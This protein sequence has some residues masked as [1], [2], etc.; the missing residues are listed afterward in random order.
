MIE[1]IRWHQMIKQNL[2][3]RHK[4]ERLPPSFKKSILIYAYTGFI[5]SID[6]LTDDN[7]KTDIRAGNV[8]L[9]YLVGN[10]V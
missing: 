1:V 8:I 6:K 3:R 10:Y 9:D 2:K 7:I 4:P 5:T